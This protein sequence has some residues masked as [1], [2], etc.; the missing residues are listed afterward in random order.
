MVHISVTL[1]LIFIVCVT[2][3]ALGVIHT[4]GTVN[5]VSALALVGDSLLIAIFVSTVSA[6][7][8]IWPIHRIRKRL[9]S[10]TSSIREMTDDKIGEKLE[11]FGDDEISKLG[12]AFN[13]MSDKY[14][15]IEKQRTEFVSNAS[16]ELKTPLSSIKLMA[17]SIIQTPDIEMDYVREF[18][19]DMNEEVERLNRIVNKLLYITKLDTLTETM[20]GPLELINLRDVVTGVRKN[21]APIADMENKT[22]DVKAEEDILIMANKDML[23]QALYN[24][25]D[26]ALKYTGE[27]G[28]VV[29]ELTKDKKKAVIS[30]KDN[31]V[32]ISSE[33]LHR[34]FDRFYRVDKARSRETGGTGLG[35][36]IAYSA[37]EFH[38]GTIEVESTPGEGSLFNIIL[39]LVDWL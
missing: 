11:I 30:V 22:L 26:N 28:E 1:P 29:I 12:E 23:W 3:A 8:V 25:A 38:N 34:I 10:Y 39:P 31:G 27:D 37:V 21:L 24:I 19:T 2:M 15:I 6:L 33:D 18:L 9:T 16:H 35:L 36:S 4:N 5:T 20:S 32:G 13:D 7:A 17:D 14:A